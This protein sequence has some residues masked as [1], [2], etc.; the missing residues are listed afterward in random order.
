MYGM[1]MA[2][3]G[4]GSEEEVSSVRKKL[5]SEEISYVEDILKPMDKGNLKINVKI[6]CGKWAIELA[7][8]S[9]DIKADLLIVGDEGK[10]GFLDRLFPHDLEEILSN[11][12]CNLLIIKRP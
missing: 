12:P 1:K 10:L 4:E 7:K 9:E 3:A 2:T 5:V 8:F 6:T 11:L